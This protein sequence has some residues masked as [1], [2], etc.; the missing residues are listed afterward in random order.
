[1]AIEIRTAQVTV[2]AQTPIAAGFSQAI[3]FP[4]RVVDQINIKVPPG[5]RGQLGFSIGTGGM[6]VIPADIG[7]YIVT[8]DEE[9][10]YPLTG[11]W[12]SGSWEVFAY[13]TGNYPHTLYLTFL[14]ELVPQQATSPAPLDLSTLAPPAP[15]AGNSTQ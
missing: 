9:I 11:Y 3:T 10:E 4:A 5:P 6:P 14:L 2:P 15:L 8:D 12:N 13:N 1:M 7:D